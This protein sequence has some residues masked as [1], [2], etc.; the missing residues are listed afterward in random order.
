MARIAIDTRH[1]LDVRSYGFPLRPRCARP[2]LPEGEASGTY[3]FVTDSAMLTAIRIR[4]TTVPG[5][6]KKQRTQVPSI[7]P[8]RK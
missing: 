5:A 2:P 8:R 1:I 6:V 3:N 7:R 4:N